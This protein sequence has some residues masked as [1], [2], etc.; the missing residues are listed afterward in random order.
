MAILIL[1]NVALLAV[2]CVFTA[3]N[4]RKH[5]LRT[6]GAALLL[7]GLFIALCGVGLYLYMTHHEGAA[8][9]IITK[10][11]GWLS[12]FAVMFFIYAKFKLRQGF[13]SFKKVTERA[14][15]AEAQL[16]ATELKVQKL[17]AE[18]ALLNTKIQG[19]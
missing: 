14:K 8:T 9:G 7:I 2:I 15:E 18:I 10:A 6:E 16:V 1:F 12:S 19:E 4:E 5:I 13:E 17:K 11:I 3:F